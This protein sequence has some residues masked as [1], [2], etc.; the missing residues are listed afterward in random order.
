M[1]HVLSGLI[2]KR[3][4]IKSEYDYLTKKLAEMAEQ[5]KTIDK[6]IKIFNPELD[7]STI[8]EKRYKTKNSFFKN[9]ELALLV[10]DVLRVGGTMS[11]KEVA[12]K[13]ME[14]KGF[15]EKLF[16]NIAKL[17]MATLKRQEKSI[18]QVDTDT[19]ECFWEV[20]K[21]SARAA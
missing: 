11:T 18:R 8:K 20:I 19:H 5:I 3:T 17:V 21:L 7:T 15:E 13:V 9:G 4:E 2:T 1:E 10:M 16:V 12:L 6:T 14:K